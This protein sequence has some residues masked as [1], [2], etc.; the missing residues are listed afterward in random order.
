MGNCIADAMVGAAATVVTVHCRDDVIT[1]RV[2]VGIEECRCGHDLAAHA[3]ATLWHLVI[4]ECLLQGMWHA[5]SKRQSFDSGNLFANELIDGC[6]AG[7]GGD[8]IDVD[9]TRATNACTATEFGA[10]HVEFVAEHE[11]QRARIAVV[12]DGYTRPVN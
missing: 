4:D 10:R 12:C 7:A 2:G 11:D 5:I 1:G 3:P 8:P 6:L 9:G